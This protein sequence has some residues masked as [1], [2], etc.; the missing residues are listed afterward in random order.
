MRFILVLVL[1]LGGA[2]P[3]CA[4][5]PCA[6]YFDF[7]HLTLL[8]GQS[9]YEHFP[10]WEMLR[11][12]GLG[13]LLEDYLAAKAERSEW[14]AIRFEIDNLATTRFIF[15]RNVPWLS[16]S[17]EL[18]IAQLNRLELRHAVRIIEFFA[19]SK[20]R[21]FCPEKPESK[22]D[23]QWNGLLEGILDE[24]V[25][26]PDLSFFDGRRVIV[27]RVGDLAIVYQDER[28]FYELAG[29]PLDFELEEFLPV[30]VGDRYVIQRQGELLVLERGQVIARGRL[31]AHQDLRSC[32]GPHEFWAEA[33]AKWV[34]VVCGPTA[35]LSYS[36]KQNRFYSIQV[37]PYRCTCSSVVEEPL[38]FRMECG[39]E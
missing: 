31:P 6:L 24:T 23:E 10:L 13:Q 17:K 33:C 25:G 16:R 28:L 22:T 37:D 12:R 3:L 34:N 29:Q 4:T 1:V 18:W 36:A 9:N 19:S 26:E 35:V 27:Y 2:R 38:A 5:N 15:G 39:Q 32:D 30:R 21:S 7:P 8:A 20:W 11:A 14:S